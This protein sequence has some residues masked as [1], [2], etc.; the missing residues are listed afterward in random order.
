VGDFYLWGRIE[1]IGRQQFFVTVS[2]V[3]APAVATQRAEI[4]VKTAIA[5]NRQAAV[6][7]RNLLMVE[8]GKAVQARGDRAVDTEDD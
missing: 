5:S 4:I 7:S 3:P 2:A 8:V 1:Q 6:A